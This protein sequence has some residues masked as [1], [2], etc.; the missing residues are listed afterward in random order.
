MKQYKTQ[1]DR[2]L[3]IQRDLRDYEKR[4]RDAG[5][6]NEPKLSKEATIQGPNSYI[7]GDTTGEWAEYLRKNQRP[8][9]DRQL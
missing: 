2:E 5:L 7:S 9:Y 3:E 6:F 1:S 4:C 8:D